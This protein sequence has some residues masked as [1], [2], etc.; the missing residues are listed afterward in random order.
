MGAAG[1][2]HG[3]LAGELRAAIGAERRDRVVL[4][5]GPVPGLPSKT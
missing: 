1:F 2:G 3:A 4:A 5:P